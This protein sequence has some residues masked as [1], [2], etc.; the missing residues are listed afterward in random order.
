MRGPPVIHCASIAPIAMTTR[1]LT[2]SPLDWLML[3]V[4]SILWGGSFIL[5]KI[6]VAAVSP[7]TVALGRVGIAALINSSLTQS[8]VVYVIF[9]LDIIAGKIKQ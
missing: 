1:P 8:G 7:L 3:V 5:N 6:A 9:A 2:M 4:L